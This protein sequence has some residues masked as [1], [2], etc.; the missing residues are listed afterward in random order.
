MIA[1]TTALRIT[2]YR[3]PHTRTMPKYGNGSKTATNIFYEQPIRYA[4]G[5]IANQ[6]RRLAKK[7]Q[8]R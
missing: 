3:R 1:A 4:L 7:K 6:C 8:H 2:A 5:R